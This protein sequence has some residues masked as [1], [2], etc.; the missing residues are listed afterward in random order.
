MIAYDSLVE[1]INR[2]I[3]K[4]KIEY[5]IVTNPA[6]SLPLVK[7]KLYGLKN[8]IK[9]PKDRRYLKFCSLYSKTETSVAAIEYDAN[10]PSI[11]IQS[12]GTT[13]KPKTIVHSDLAI[14]KMVHS[15]SYSDLPLGLGKT[16]L[17]ALP[18]WIAYGLCDAVIMPLTLGTKVELSP[19]F[20][21]DTIVR[22]LGKFTISFAAPFHYRYLL[23]RF[24]E[25]SAEEKKNLVMIEVAIT[26]GDKIS[27][28]EN[29]QFEKILGIVL[30][31]GYGNNEGL[32]VLTVNPCK[33]N[34][35]GTVGIPKYGDII[36]CCDIET[37]KE[38][39]YGETGEVC[40]LTDTLFIGYENNTEETDK[41]KRLHEDANYWLHT[42]DLGSVD[43]DGF[44][45]LS[46]RITRVIVRQGFKI[47]AYTI[48]DKISELEIVKECVAV[49]VKDETEEHVPMAFVVLNEVCIENE[50]TVRE[51][52]ADKLQQDLKEYEIP[53]Y[54][55]FIDAMP[56]TANNKYDYRLLEN[57]G[58]EYV[59]SIKA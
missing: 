27:Y 52:I 30:V 59:D 54:I 39:P 49:S 12:S 18:P 56:Y 34:K 55:Q 7:R 9:I 6:E 2:I 43:E 45:S 14:G 48:E 31:N 13:G 3:N 5:V 24:S 36:V 8:H 58:N 44:I 11:M 33:Y 41:C 17:V 29:E 51:L 25:L 20:D 50:N 57:I 16:A 10:R 28:E 32:G 26:G 19:S 4:T 37:G 21:S 23:E 38:L 1:K 46:G 22:Y 47:A 15:I 40:C 42:G 35:Y 53:K